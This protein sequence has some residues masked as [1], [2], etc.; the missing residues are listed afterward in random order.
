MRE[1]TFEIAPTLRLPPTIERALLKTRIAGSLAMINVLVIAFD[2]GLL[3]RG[4]ILGG[5]L[6]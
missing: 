1:M 2:L 5:L 4:D 6:R 3:V